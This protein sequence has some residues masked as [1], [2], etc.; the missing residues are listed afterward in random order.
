MGRHFNSIGISFPILLNFGFDET[1]FPIWSNFKFNDTSF[2]VC[3]ISASI[4][5]SFLFGETS[6]PDRDSF[7]QIVIETH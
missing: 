4:E 6:I 2:P 1:S 3:W 5:P 7:L